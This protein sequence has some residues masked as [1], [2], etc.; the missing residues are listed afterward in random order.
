MEKKITVLGNKVL[1]DGMLL[2]TANA[3]IIDFL[4]LEDLVILL[5]DSNKLRSDRNIFC[6]GLDTRIKWQI[7][8]TDKLHVENYYTSLY[9]SD[10]RR[11]KAYNVNGIEVTL[12]KSNGV[13]INKELI[14]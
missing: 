1:C 9:L 10:D 2:F 5:L 4:V 13:I 8:P 3:E 12:D 14:K 6:Y 11:L 7:P